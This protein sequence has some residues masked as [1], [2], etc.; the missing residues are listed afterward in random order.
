M[1]ADVNSGL[2]TIAVNVTG[3]RMYIDVIDWQPFFGLMN[4]TGVFE[5]GDV[6]VALGT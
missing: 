1:L 6:P 3:V 2:S 4:V 5:S